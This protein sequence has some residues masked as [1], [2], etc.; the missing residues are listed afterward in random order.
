MR[1]L[2]ML[3]GRV[4]VRRLLS[5]LP[6]EARALYGAAIP[7]T[8]ARLQRD[9]VTMHALLV[10]SAREIGAL[11]LLIAREWLSLARSLLRAARTP[12]WAAELRQAAHSL[13][14]SP[15]YTVTV[16][17]TLG[18][19]V[20]GLTVVFSVVRA[21]LLAPLPYGSPESLVRLYETARGGYSG[22]T[23]SMP[24]VLAWQERSRRL[25]HIVLVGAGGLAVVRVQESAVSARA[26]R[27]SRGTFELLAA[28]PLLGALPVAQD[29]EPGGARWVVLTHG[30][31]ESQLAAD[32]AVVGRSLRI[33]GAELQVAAVMRPGFNFPDGTTELLLP[34]RVVPGM[35]LAS[36]NGRWARLFQAYARLRPGA[37]LETATAELRTISAALEQEFGPPNQGMTAYPRPLKSAMLG[38]TRLLLLIL[39]LS[40][41]LVLLV[42]CS[43]VAALTLVRTAAR[44]RE[45]AIR[46]VHGASRV[47]IAR[48]LGSE[49][50]WVCALA[51]VLVTYLAALLLP[52]A[53]QLI[54]ATMPHSELR[55][56]QNVPVAALLSLLSAF[57][58]FAAVLH[59][60]ATLPQLAQSLAS[61]GPRSTSS[62]RQLRTR[63]VLVTAQVAVAIALLV[64]GGALLRSYFALVHQSVGFQARNVALLTANTP[65]QRYAAP[66]RVIQFYDAVL[67]G[68][69]ALPGVLRVGLVNA[70]PL[71]G[72]GTS[73]TFVPEGKTPQSGQE[74]SAVTYTI[75]QDYPAALG[76]PLLA[77]R[78]LQAVDTFPLAEGILVSRTLAFQQFGSAAQALGR[79]ISLGGVTSNNPWMTIVGVVGDVREAALGRA[80]GALIY[81]RYA[82]QTITRTMT[83]ALQS[84]GD[85][86]A[87]ITQLGHLVREI[88]P[89]VATFDVQ[90]LEA[91]VTA[92]AARERLTASLAA[93]FGLLA[94]LLACLGVVG[95]LGEMAL[96]QRRAH[97]IRLALGA[98]RA[99]VLAAATRAGLSLIITGA[100]LG[101]LLAWIGSSAIKPFVFGV[102]S[103][104]VPTLLAGVGAFVLIGSLAAIV[105]AWKATRS[106]LGTVLRTE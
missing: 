7:N 79:R 76:I 72:G 83:F 37:S 67:E 62:R 15:I 12:A 31:W 69:R 13:R 46:V 22:T 52:I 104:D 3:A 38:N 94:L 34:L 92:S 40:A 66:G 65:G 18:L 36:A 106:A 97:A 53:A 81:R 50:F 25:E 56:W 80:P 95:L 14:R 96:Q 54:P 49:I 48:L 6:M 2:L 51:A 26:A 86:L 9:A 30:F 82:A 16:V 42:A 29:F 75:D 59:P 58:L 91:V 44:E 98:T 103:L 63:A 70:A 41:G 85:P 33:D 8:F 24:N 4:A 90:P 55:A 20:A 17:L 57:V 88:D 84:S 105:P 45:T 28:R 89:D 64:T 77:G 87:L 73:W 47:D 1:R 32:T 5:L 68:A 21:T 102:P 11:I 78:Q 10:C 61:A 35:G 60:R 27:V 100:A 43:N 99:S 23:T 101:V 71:S 39:L 19:G 93:G 74:P